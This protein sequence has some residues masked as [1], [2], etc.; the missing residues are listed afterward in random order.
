[1]GGLEGVR[2]QKINGIF[3]NCLLDIR[4]SWEGRPKVQ[5]ALH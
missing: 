5:W 2:I 4:D 1:L 3:S